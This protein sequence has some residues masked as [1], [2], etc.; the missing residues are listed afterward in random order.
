MVGVSQVTDQVVI[1]QGGSEMVVWLFEV[2]G[3]P[4]DFTLWDGRI[5]I[6]SQRSLTEL[7]LIDL[8]VDN[9]LLSLT[10]DGRVEADFTVDEVVKVPAGSSCVGELCLVDPA[11]NVSFPI[12][13]E[14]ESPAVATEAPA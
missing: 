2:D 7:I 1:P 6:R 10:H 11:G 12:R 5:Q 9:G 14:F 3:V 8:S 13:I 4:R